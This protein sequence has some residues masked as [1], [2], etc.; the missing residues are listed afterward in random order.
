MVDLRPHVLLTR[1]LSA[2]GL[3][4]DDEN[5]DDA[6]EGETEYDPDDPDAM[7]ED[8]PNA[9]RIS[10]YERGWLACER[11]RA[12]EGGAPILKGRR[13]AEAIHGRTMLIQLIKTMRDDQ[14]RRSLRMDPDVELCLVTAQ[15]WID[16]TDG[17]AGKATD[18]VQPPRYV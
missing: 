14:R 4:H 18:F 17:S 12:D 16:N 6:V 13:L 10:D 5:W 1:L 15:N 9:N 3:H 11:N 2:I 7:P 8:N